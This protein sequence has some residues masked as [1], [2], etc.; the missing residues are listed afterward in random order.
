K[1][2]KQSHLFD[3]LTKL[4]DTTV[5]QPYAEQSAPAPA[6][7][8]Q[9]VEHLKRLLLLVEDNPV[10][11]KLAMLQLKKLGYTAHTAN[12][13][14]E[15]L[16]ALESNRYDLILMDCQMPEMDGYEATAVIRAL[17]AKNGGHI[18][19]IAM[20]ANAMTAN[21]MAGDREHCIASGMDDYLAKPVSIEQLRVKIQRW[22][23]E[24][25]A[26]QY[27]VV[28]DQPAPVATY[29]DVLVSREAGRRERPT[30]RDGLVSQETGRRELPTIPVIDNKALDKISALQVEGETDLLSEIIASYLSDAPLKL[31]GI[32]S[33]LAAGDTNGLRRS[34]HS[35]KSSSAN[36]GA[37]TLS[38]L[39][40]EL[41]EMGRSG[42]LQQASQKHQQASQK[43]QQ[44]QREFDAARQ[45]LEAISSGAA[46]AAPLSRAV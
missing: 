39:C 46:Q 44:A 36:L 40:K 37:M 11:Q 19:I 42:N 13:G 34:A 5:L 12:N 24:Q 20:T 17:E 2:L 9:A 10:N 21:A 27:A 29:K 18:P 43:H 1:P 23:P 28:E 14:C 3:C 31:E 25:L 26:A 4:F 16:A 15:A 33:A 22:L 45:A 38:G 7:V 35:L 8:A 6:P 41:E 32:R 30:Y